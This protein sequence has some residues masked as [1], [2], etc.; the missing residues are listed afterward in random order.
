V[1]VTQPD[2][3]E[4]LQVSRKA[5]PEVIQAAYRRLATKYHPDTGGKSAS[6]DMMKLLNEGYEVLRDPGKRSAYDRAMNIETKSSTAPHAPSHTYTS[7]GL[8]RDW[9]L[10]KTPFGMTFIQG[11]YYYLSAMESKRKFRDVDVL[12]SLGL[13]NYQISF[14]V[15]STYYSSVP[16]WVIIELFSYSSH[17]GENGYSVAISLDSRDNCVNLSAFCGDKVKLLLQ[18]KRTYLSHNPLRVICKL[19]YQKFTVICNGNTVISRPIRDLTFTEMIALGIQERRDQKTTQT[20][21]EV[22]FSELSIL[23]V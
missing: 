22:R 12:H 18:D 20:C 9:P 10:M 17:T 23:A 11:D 14:N 5:D 19:A 6:A 16:P 13:A 3:Y 4:I 7:L 1:I 15:D 2:Y 8:F 21:A